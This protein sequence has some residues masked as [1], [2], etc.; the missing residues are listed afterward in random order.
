MRDLVVMG[1][2]LVLCLLSPLNPR[3]GLYGYY[4][5]A[6]MRPDILAWSGPNRYSLLIAVFTLLSNSGRA[7][8]NLPVLI[9]SPLC[10]TMLLL[11]VVITLSIPFAVKPELCYEPYS[12][13]IR[14]I[15]MAF[16]IPLA[17]R[18]KREIRI[19]M[20]VMAASIGLLAGKFG[21][22]G[23]LAGGARFGQGYGGML[24]DNNTMALAFVLA[25]PLCWF[26]RLLVTQL[27]ARIGFATL[28]LLSFGGVVFTHSRGGV[29]AAGIA[30][31]LIAWRAKHRLLV[32]LMVVGFGIGAV[33]LVR[34]SLLD[35]MATISAP[36]EEASAKSRVILVRAAVK[37]WLDYPLLGVGFTENNQQELIS[38]YVPA[39]Y[40]DGYQGKVIHNT[41]LQMLVDAGIFSLLLY[42]WLLFGGI[43]K[44]ERSIRRARED[45]GL[46][47]AAIPL[48]LQTSLVAYAAGSTF[49][50]RSSFDFFYI[51]IMASA[52]WLE[53]ERRADE[54]VDEVA[55]PGMVR[56]PAEVS[57]VEYS[58]A[59]TGEKPWLGQPQGSSRL[60][61]GREKRERN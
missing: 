59:S 40:K 33:Y 48:A 45:G 30:M 16:L 44:L 7:L 20:V 49:L 3:L 12:L 28:A 13:F 43:W 29:L 41:Y 36:L 2:T 19:L 53:I 24:S 51:L 5:F 50:S 9:R 46:E 11:V 58:G 34:D 15:L 32:G 10:R 56:M 60:R 37:M 22:A 54:T 38:S 55:A 21:L 25:I 26:S 39:E 17:I 47:E 1:I 42:C 8:A 23:I 6:L 57:K 31:L 35:R 4:W 18:D 52:A 14:M 61:M 27:W